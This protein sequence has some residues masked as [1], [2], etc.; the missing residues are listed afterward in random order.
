[1]CVCVC[2]SVCVVVRV[3]RR[4]S[5]TYG[6]NVFVAVCALQCVCVCVAVCVL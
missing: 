2:C 1:V 5:D 6:G 3:D 4:I